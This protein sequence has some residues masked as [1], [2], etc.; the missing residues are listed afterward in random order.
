[1]L[2]R[3]LI[4]AGI[5]LGLAVYFA[6]DLLLGGGLRNYINIELEWLIVLAAV[7]F[8]FLAAASFWECLRLVRG[9]ESGHAHGRLVSLGVLGIPL[10]LAAIHPDVPLGADAARG[11]LSTSVQP[12]SFQT[13]QRDPLSYNVLDWLRAFS[14]E[15]DL[16]SFDGQ[17]ARL[18]GF[19][20]RDLAYP[21]D[22]FLLARIT[23]S[24]CV[25]DASAIGLPIRHEGAAEYQADQWVQV[26]GRFQL[27]Y[28]GE[29]LLPILEA[30]E[31]V[32]V[33]PPEQPYLYP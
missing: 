10:V 32:I 30:E 11:R 5:T 12:A 8:V 13:L 23:L 22:M 28:F 15:A 20:Y 33:E 31:I 9:G 25:A 18:L 4:Q 7:L 26:R 29:E 1:M 14:R 2:W 21:E 6:L 16:A 17:E 19:V 3:R 27:G 24:C